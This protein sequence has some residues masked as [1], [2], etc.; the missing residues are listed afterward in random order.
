MS[1]LFLFT[2]FLSLLFCRYFLFLTSSLILMVLCRIG[3]VVEVFVF[4]LVSGLI[5]LLSSCLHRKP[6]S[7]WRLRSSKTVKVSGVSQEVRREERSCCL[8][9][10]ALISEQKMRRSKRP[11]FGSWR[12]FGHWSRTTS[13]SWRRLF[14]G[15]GSSTS[16]SNM[17]RGSVQRLR[18]YHLTSHTFLLSALPYLDS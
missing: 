11:L 9:S 4:V 7:W 13:S 2:F 10:A 1:S 14:G 6:M 8:I 3:L 16:S 12:C 5:W 18:R 17:L 15:G